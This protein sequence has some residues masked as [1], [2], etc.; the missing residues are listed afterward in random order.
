MTQTRIKAK[1]MET[2]PGD[3]TLPSGVRLRDL[4]ER[5]LRA[6]DDDTEFW[7]QWWDDKCRFAEENERGE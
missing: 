6:E 3:P 1:G 5:K 2:L 4:S 7:S